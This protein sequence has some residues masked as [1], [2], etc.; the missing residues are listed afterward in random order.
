MLLLVLCFE[1]EAF[2]E[3]SLSSS[4]LLDGHYISK[5]NQASEK[6]VLGSLML[7]SEFKSK[8]SSLHISLLGTHSTI[9][10]TDDCLRDAQIFSNIDALGQDT[11]KFYEIFYEYKFKD[12]S[13]LDIGWLD[14]SSNFNTTEPSSHL[15]N[16]SFGTAAD[17]G[18]TGYFGPSIYPITAF[19]LSYSKVFN[20]DFYLKAALT[21]PL[22]PDNFR[23]KRLQTDIKLDDKNYFSVLEAGVNKDQK[24]KVSFG[25]WELNVQEG[26]LPD[27]KQSGAYT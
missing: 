2:N 10:P 4:Y 9:S 13:L 5:D 19:G 15:L 27:F 1:V 16:S 8:R 23:S 3:V 18:N 7:Y 12:T 17:L 21:D 26:L 6:P 11:L 14:L 24:F 20:N 25:F 22:N